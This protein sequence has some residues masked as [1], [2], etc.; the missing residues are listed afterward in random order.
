MLIGNRVIIGLVAVFLLA[1]CAEKDLILPGERE[2]IRA[3]LTDDEGSAGGIVTNST[4][5]NTTAPA[6]L[7]AETVN[8][9]WLQRIGSPTT[10]TPHPALSAAPQRVWSVSI[11]AGDGKRNRITADPVVADGRIYTLD[12]QAT[13][14]AVSTAGQVVWSRDLTPPNDSPS[15]ASGGGLSFGNGKVFVSSG[16]GILVALNAATGEVIWEQAL[17]GTGSGSPTVFG[18]I[19]YI[20]SGDD[21][22]WALDADTGRIKWRLAAAPDINNVIGGPAPA[23]SDKYVVFAFGAGELQGAFRKGGLRLWDAQ[24]AGR[25]AGLSQSLVADVT[26]D[27]VISGDK[28]YVGTHSGRLVALRLANGE[29]LWTAGEGPLSPAWPAGDSLYMVSDKNELLRLRAEDGTR[30]WGQKLPFFTSNRPKRQAEVFAHYGPV[31]AGGQVI[32]ASNDGQIRFFD[33]VSGALNR[34]VEIPGGATSNPV[35]A[36]RT[37]YVVSTKG[38]LYAF[39]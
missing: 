38:E 15:D 28:V 39:R 13:V 33:P 31:V 4:T 30:V 1:S 6:K 34:S 25:R 35:V 19:I 21:D 18:D 27:P 5:Q 2:D 26:G 9:E 24:V 17:R 32:V 8:A 23:V 7:P 11:G 16:F 12:A 20:V 36:G 29:R 14:T 22:A 37:L 10:R 3:V